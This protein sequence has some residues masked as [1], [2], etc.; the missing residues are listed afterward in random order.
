[1][2]SGFNLMLLG[3]HHVDVKCFYNLTKKY[4]VSFK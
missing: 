3:L 1:M 2:I 4:F